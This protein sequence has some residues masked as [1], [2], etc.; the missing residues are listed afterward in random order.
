MT[1]RKPERLVQIEKKPRSRIR[2]YGAKASTEER[3]WQIGRKAVT[4]EWTLS[5]RRGHHT[6]CIGTSIGKAP[7]NAGKRETVEVERRAKAKGTNLGILGPL[8]LVPHTQRPN[9]A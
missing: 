9:Y 4:N 5:R 2:S 3:A 8:V 1:T 7:P 6:T